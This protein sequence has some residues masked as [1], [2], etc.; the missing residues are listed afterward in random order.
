MNKIQQITERRRSM[1][2][3]AT[4]DVLATRK[5]ELQNLIDTYGYDAVCAAT[6]WKASSITTYLRTK[7]PKI[8]G[9]VITKAER[10]LKEIY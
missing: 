9:D 5:Q 10:I 2:S 1:A 6:G 7:Y 8:S 4:D 3:Q